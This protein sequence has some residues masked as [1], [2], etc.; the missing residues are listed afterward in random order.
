MPPPVPSS[1]PVKPEQVAAFWAW[2]RENKRRMD[3]L[4]DPD[5]PFWDEA[6][7]ELAK[8]NPELR[9]ALS[10]L[11]GA[12]KGEDREFVLTASCD[13]ELFSMVDA[14]VNAA[15]KLAGWQWVALKPPM[16]FD[17]VTEFEDL[18]LDPREMWF[19][20][21]RDSARPRSLGIRIAVPG[22]TKRRADQYF[23]AVAMVLETGLGERAAA[24]EL[25]QLEVVPLPD[26]LKAEGYAKLTELPVYMEWNRTNRLPARGWSGIAEWKSGK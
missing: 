4:D 15:P 22:F 5:E 20:P 11:E 6:L 7:A 12:P 2:F 10:S 21:L 8:L 26:N 14:V 19:F 3:A 13:T 17:F 23:D 24:T 25:E 9:F 18:T 1:S 16:G